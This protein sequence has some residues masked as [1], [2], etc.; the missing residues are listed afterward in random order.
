MNNKTDNADQIQRDIRCF[1]TRVSRLITGKKG[2][3]DEL[4]PRVAPIISFRNM[5]NPDGVVFKYGKRKGQLK[6]CKHKDFQ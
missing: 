1:E 3:P 4:V 5:P 2:S 6:P